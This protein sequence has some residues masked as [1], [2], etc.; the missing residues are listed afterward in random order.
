MLVLLKD[1]FIGPWSGASP[2]WVVV[3]TPV[4][5]EKGRAEVGLRRQGD[6]AAVD[7]FLRVWSIGVAAGVRPAVRLHIPDSAARCTWRGARLLILA[8]VLSV[9]DSILNRQV[10]ERQHEIQITPDVMDLLTIP[11]VEAGLELEQA[12]DRGGQPVPGWLSG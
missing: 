3:S 8:L 2:A 9:P 4:G 5:Y 1:R 11:S 6:Q 7:R 10:E 12:I